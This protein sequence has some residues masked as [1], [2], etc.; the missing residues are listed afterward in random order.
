M[1]DGEVGGESKRDGDGDGWL[2]DWLVGV[3]R[4]VGAERWGEGWIG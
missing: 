2:V 4:V 3:R 1:E